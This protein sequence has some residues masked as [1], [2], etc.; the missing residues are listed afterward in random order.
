M[1]SISGVVLVLLFFIFTRQFDG[2]G[3]L[4]LGYTQKSGVTIFFVTG[5]KSHTVYEVSQ[6]TRFSLSTT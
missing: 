1:I 6:I 3:G 2:E 4:L 5:K